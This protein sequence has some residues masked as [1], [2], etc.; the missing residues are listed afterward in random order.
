[1]NG[2]INSLQSASGAKFRGLKVISRCSEQKHELSGW[3]LF[4]RVS[5]PPQVNS[6][7][8]FSFT[9]DA[10]RWEHIYWISADKHCGVCVTTLQEQCVAGLSRTAQAGKYFH[11]WTDLNRNSERC[12]VRGQEWNANCI[13]K[14]SSEMKQEVMMVVMNAVQ[15]EGDQV[16]LKIWHMSRCLLA[17]WSVS[18]FLLIWLVIVDLICQ[19]HLWNQFAAGLI[20]VCICNASHLRQL[21]TKQKAD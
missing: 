17:L 18:V 12:C 15:F 8:L 6:L 1:M 19:M 7:C 10:I 2:Y 11:F 13:S 4:C 9:C 5:A 21:F 20:F 14:A 16:S 3:C